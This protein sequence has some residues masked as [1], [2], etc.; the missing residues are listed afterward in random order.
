MPPRRRVRPLAHSP[1]RIAAVACL[2]GGHL[3][4]EPHVSGPSCCCCSW[5]NGTAIPPHKL[6]IVPHCSTHRESQPDVAALTTSE[7][8]SASARRAHQGPAEDR[9]MAPKS[10]HLK[11]DGPRLLPD[12]RVDEVAQSRR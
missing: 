4:Q 3:T 11:V 5:S 10:L 2:E 6:G 7:V 12:S 1:T 8:L 9:L